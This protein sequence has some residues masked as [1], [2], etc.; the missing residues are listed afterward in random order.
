[1]GI[2][3]EP[4]FVLDGFIFIEYSSPW[5]Y[6]QY[7]LGI[8]ISSFSLLYRH[9][10]AIDEYEAAH[11]EAAL[12]RYVSGQNPIEVMRRVFETMPLIEGVKDLFSYIRKSGG[13]WI[14]AGGI[15]KPLYLRIL[16]EAKLEPLK[17]D[18]I[19]Y[20]EEENPSPLPIK[21]GRL[22]SYEFVSDC[23]KELGISWED[24]I[25]VGRD[26]Y[27]KEIL[28]DSSVGIALN[29]VDDEVKEYADR[30]IR[31]SLRELIYAIEGEM[32][33]YGPG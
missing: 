32:L 19:W 21:Y 20:Y 27:F 2:P 8:S 7:Q 9:G 28:R 26:K 17:F 5:E 12:V 18:V 16:R 3:E 24:V 11:R 33:G 23:L 15:P 25:S 22:R 6:L 13:R 14:L 4:L 1:M 31:G 30:V 29:P 10:R